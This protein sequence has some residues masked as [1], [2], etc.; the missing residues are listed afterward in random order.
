MTIPPLYIRIFHVSYHQSGDWLVKVPNSARAIS[1]HDSCKA[2]LA[3][4]Q[5]LARR[6]PP[7]EVVTF[8]KLGVEDSRQSFQ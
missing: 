3:D 4:A 6:N 7:S 5:M 2:A 8:N 1:F